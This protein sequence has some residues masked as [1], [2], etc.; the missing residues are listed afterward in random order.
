M[1]MAA[2]VHR[3]LGVFPAPSTPTPPPRQLSPRPHHIPPSLVRCCSS[4]PVC[5]ATVAVAQPQ[6]FV[7]VTF[8]KFVSIDDPRA[9]VSR[10]LHFLQGRDIHGRIY[11]NEQGINAQYSGPHKDAV[12]YADWL[13]KDHRFRDLLVQTSPSLCGHAF[14]RLKLRYKPSLVQLEGGCSHLPLVDPSMRATPLTP[15]EWRERLEARKCLD[16]SSSEAAG[17]SSGRRLL[18]LD[19]RNDYEWDIGHFQGAQ[20]PNVD[21]FRSTSFG[22]SESEQEMDSSDPLNGI[23]KENTDIL[24]YCTGGIRCDVYST[25]LR[26]KGF[27]NLYTLKGGVSNYLKEEGSAGWVGNLFVFDGRLSLPPA[28]YKPGAG[29][30]DDEEEEEGRNR[31]SSELGRCYACGSEVVE[32]RHRNCANI[33]C[34]RLY[35]CCGRCVEELRGCCGEGCTAAPRLRPLLPS[36]QRYHK[37]HLYRH[38]DLGAPSSPS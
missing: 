27:R 37:W 38:L 7:V 2:A 16:V 5:A 23:D 21:C 36:H 31:S 8:Y 6:E 3:F 25:I 24:M 14:P 29:D 34:N 28:T 22:L 10:H 20:R 35:L 13:R 9:E 30:D 17:D 19:V 4:S 33:D 11:M 15:S 26:K 32:L 1:A 18:L 12:A